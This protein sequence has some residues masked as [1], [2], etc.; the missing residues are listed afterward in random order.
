MVARGVFRIVIIIRTVGLRTGAIVVAAVE[1]AIGIDAIG[2]VPHPDIILYLLIFFCKEE[3]GCRYSK[4]LVW[5]LV[6]GYDHG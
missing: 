5:Q 4:F 2:I 1:S 3:K 6:L